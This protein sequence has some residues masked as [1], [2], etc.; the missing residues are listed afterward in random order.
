[1]SEFI[2]KIFR[3]IVFIIILLV[4]YIAFKA[5]EMKNYYSHRTKEI[6]QNW[7]EYRCKPGMIPLA[8]QFGPSGTST[9]ENALQCGKMFLE[10][11]F[12]Y[13]MIPFIK[14]FETLI[15]VVFDLV[16]SVRNIRKMIYYLR[17]SIREHLLD[18]ANMIYGYGKKISYLFN[19]ITDVMG[20][21]FRVFED[22]FF[23]IGYSITTLESLWNGSIGAVGRFFCFHKNT[24][25]SMNDN[26]QKKIYKIKPGDIIKEGGKVLA[27]HKYS[28]KNINLYNYNNIIVSGSH[29]VFEDKPVKVKNSSISKSLP[30]KEKYI[31]CLTTEKGKILINNTLFADYMEIEND[32]D[33]NKILQKVL[34]K[35]NNKKELI[36][37]KNEKVWGFH[38]N[39]KIKLKSGI[40][41]NIKDIKI[42]DILE[43][44]SKVEGIMKINAD[45]IKLYKNNN[46]ISSG[47]T[48][49]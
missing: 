3:L 45:N 37:D 17:D 30:I 27:I 12:N 19:T 43:N 22:I 36:T 49:V 4:V 26:S 41:K 6:K 21:I 46:V 7:G 32:E 48:I 31:Y 23:A 38:K 24:L 5:F 10:N 42:N 1:M 9:M 2:T 13:F 16:E 39:T 29:I 18:I 8:G 33:I 40:Y 34:Q 35:L 44:N 47:N 14:F 25:I 15:D 11:S 28:G 20:K